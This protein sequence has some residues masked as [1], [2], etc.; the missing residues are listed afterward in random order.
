VASYV[1]RM[2]SLVVGVL[3]LAGVASCG[4]S[5]SPNPGDRVPTCEVQRDNDFLSDD[6]SVRSTETFR[7]V[8]GD[9]RAWLVEIES[10]YP[11]TTVTSRLR[12]DPRGRPWS[13]VQS[14]PTSTTTTMVA[15]DGEGRLASASHLTRTLVPPSSIE[16]LEGTTW[17]RYGDDRRDP[18]RPLGVDDRIYQI[19]LEAG[20]RW[21][22]LED[23]DARGSTALELVYDQY[24]QMIGTGRI[25]GG[26]ERGFVEVQRDVDGRIIFGDTPWRVPP[27]YTQDDLDR[28]STT[29]YVETARRGGFPHRAERG[30]RSSYQF[31]YRGC[32]DA[33]AAALTPWVVE[34]PY[35][36]QR[37]Y[38]NPQFA[39]HFD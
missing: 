25:A 33:P 36:V 20:G 13:C 14:G 10:R 22:A 38:C 23:I 16:D 3:L 4:A 37:I 8:I 11:A 5:P 12:Y 15:Y 32:D 30:F 28:P 7:F 35:A 17:I 24:G 39:P 29:L 18:P 26:R 19:E 6:R 2:R 27:E 9:A 34:I 31:S 21:R 1:L